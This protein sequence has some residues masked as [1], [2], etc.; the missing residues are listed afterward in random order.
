MT[1]IERTIS[2]LKEL[3]LPAMADELKSLFGSEQYS[4]M[5]FLQLI[6]QL[7]DVEMTSRINHAIEKR[8]KAARLSDSSA[9]LDLIDYK[10]E[11]RINK[12]LIDQLR[13]NEYITSGRNVL[14]LGA[15]GCGKS[16]I[17]NALAINA[18][19]KYRT[20]FIRLSELLSDLAIAK[21]EGNIRKQYK[22]YTRYDLL[23]ID[24]F[25]LT[26]TTSSEQ[27]DL[28]EIFEYRGRGRSTI[29]CS[30]LSPEEWHK[31]LG[32]SHVADAILDRIT[33][34]S[35]TIELFGESMRKHQQ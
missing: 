1:E 19:E 4:K 20:R 32:G 3:R 7:C 31:K 30:Q 18:C 17:S 33:N 9:R 10:P 12:A 35:Y 26:D 14:I 34:N 11:R 22:A 21:V 15:T 23:V 25:L 24:D 13:T 8:I 29:L 27:K 28:M 2:K 6:E 5:D 16:F